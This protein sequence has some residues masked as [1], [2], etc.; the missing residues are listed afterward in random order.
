MRGRFSSRASKDQEAAK[1]GMPGC[2]C[3]FRR[4]NLAA[5]A[6][7]LARQL[8]VAIYTYIPVWADRAKSSCMLLQ[9][10]PRNLAPPRLIRPNSAGQRTPWRIVVSRAHATASD[11]LFALFICYH[12]SYTR[13][14]RASDGCCPSSVH[15]C[16]DDL[17]MHRAVH[18]RGPQHAGKLTTQRNLIV[19]DATNLIFDMQLHFPPSTCAG[20]ACQFQPPPVKAELALGCTF[21]ENSDSVQGSSLFALPSPSHLDDKARAVPCS[22]GVHGLAFVV[23]LSPVGSSARHT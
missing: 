9:A 8:H 15:P 4:L 3:R 16:S 1:C 12:R 20:R 18:M 5:T 6:H 17:R 21:A 19:P 23:L 13:P 11:D 2:H 10:R 7:E 14:N 22:L